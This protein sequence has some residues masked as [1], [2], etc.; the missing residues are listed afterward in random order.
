MVNCV[1]L[2]DSYITKFDFMDFY[3]S[4]S[5][6][7]SKTNMAITSSFSENGLKCLGQIVN[8]RVL[9]YHNGSWILID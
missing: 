8:A 4:T 2:Y 3:T 5:T 9:W 1:Y 6:D 7:F